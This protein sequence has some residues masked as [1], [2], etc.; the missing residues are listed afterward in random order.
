MHHLVRS[1]LVPAFVL[2]AFSFEALCAQISAAAPGVFDNHNDVGATRHA[3]AVEH[4]TA[5]HSYT[6]AGG[7]ENMW[8]TNDAFHFVW[9]KVSGDVTLAADIAFLGTGGNAHRKACLIIRQSLDADSAYADAALHGDGLTSLQY[10]EDK[11]ARTYE[12]QSNVSAPKRLRIEKRGKY[13]FMSLALEGEELHP[14]GGN[15]RLL[16]EDPF[17]IG[18]AVCAHDN[19]AL[20]K[21]VFSNVELSAGSTAPSAKPGLVSTL[22]T[23]TIASRD[24]RV[25]YWTTNLIEAPNWARD[26]ASLVFN[27]RGR[28]Y[29]LP[30]TNGS[31]QLRSEER[32]VG[33]E[34]ERLCRSRWSPYH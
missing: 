8:F 32:R 18:L 34:C 24:R 21:A 2:A 13:V 11:G 5:L 6:V 22:E 14:A 27:S 9:K 17:Y 26:G 33:K 25:V 12:I 4:D 7:G 28:I 16:L 10:R 29:G 3:G 19:N 30:V 23:V 31:P 15:F 20:E 1:S